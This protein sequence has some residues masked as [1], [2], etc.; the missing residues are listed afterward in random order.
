MRRDI[1]TSTF[2]LHRKAIV[3]GGDI[4]I[5]T[6]WGGVYILLYQHPEVEKFSVVDQGRFLAFEK[7]AE[8]TETL[9]GEQGCG[10]LVYRCE[11]R[12]QLKAEV[13]EPGLTRTLR[14]GKEHTIIAL[15]NLLVRES[16]TD[17]KGMNQDLI[18]IFMLEV[19]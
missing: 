12:D 16:S 15:S 11:Q 1:E 4:F 10:V 3:A 6:S 18:F 9:F 13:I 19:T 8:K 2:D 17:P 14:P 7:H 5:H